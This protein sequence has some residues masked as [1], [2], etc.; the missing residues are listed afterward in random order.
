[1]TMDENMLKFDEKL[2]ELLAAAKKRR[3]HLI[4]R[5]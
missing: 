4:I 3:T 5:K 1:M 2:K